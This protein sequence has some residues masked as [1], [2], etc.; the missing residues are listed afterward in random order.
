MDNRFYKPDGARI[1]GQTAELAGRSHLAPPPA[2]APRTAFRR[3]PFP[4][5]PLMLAC[6]AA[7]AGAVAQAQVQVQGTPTYLQAQAPKPP[8]AASA[9]SAASG[10]GRGKAQPI[11][12]RAQELRGRPDLETVA[13]GDVEFRRGDF[14]LRADWLTYEQADDT[15]LARG[16]VRISTPSGVY[17]GPEVRLAIER[18]EGYFLRPDFELI[19]LKAGGRADRVDFLDSSRSV[20]YNARYTSCP[21]DGSGD[22][23]WV[24]ETRRVSLDLESNTGVADGA[25]LR[26]LGV[27]ILALPT[28]SF[29]LTDDRKSGW[30]PP[31]LNLDSK[32]GLEVG[33][34]YYWNIAP[35]RDATFVPRVL[36]RRGV[37]LDSEF[38]YLEPGYSGQLNLDWLP[39]DRVAGRSRYA[40]MA[41]HDGEWPQGLRWHADGVRVSDDGWWKD[42]PDA[43]RG[44]TSRLL[45]LRLGAERDFEI[46]GGRGLAYARVQ[47]WQ[48]LQGSDLSVVSPYERVPQVGARW[49]ADDAGGGLQLALESEVNRFGLPDRAGSPAEPTGSRWHAVGSLSRPWRD[50]GWWVVPKASVNAAAYRTDEAMSD[51]RRSAGRVIPTFSI[52]A[53]LELER[54]TVYFGR[55][56]RQ[57]LEP[58]LLYV[59][60]PFRAQAGLPNFDSTGKDFNFNSIYSEN[61]FSGIDRVSD[62]HQVTAGVTTRVLDAAT[63]AEALRLGI[64]QR[65]LFRTQQ[66]TPDGTPVTQRFSDV[67]LLGSTNVFTGWGLDAAVQYSA[68]I[69]RPVR[70]IVSSRWSPGEFRTVSATYRY[71]RG[72]SEQMELGW[73]WPVWKSP[74]GLDAAPGTG[75]SSS[76]SCGGS[77]YAVGRM[78]YSMKDSRITDSVLG[79]EYDAGCWIARVVSVR[80]STGR[81][82]ATT[83]LR[84]E[85]ELVG[86]SRL[87]SNPLK[88][89]KDNI[90]GYRLLREP[91]SATPDAPPSYE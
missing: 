75:T 26:F 45:P 29:P 85:L 46:A 88:V 90:P 25:V 71:A 49:R 91:R 81:S 80:L 40:L 5:R 50:A 35:N 54:E 65:Y 76:S 36:T 64:V 18:F 52:D 2:L 20:A 30:L 59:T 62:A 28:L 37:A 17:S 82:Q 72:L 48:V 41:Q 12:L 3:P 21:R 22:P 67:Y 83:G 57:T 19:K 11:V 69:A 6:A 78:N 24:M 31:S 43:G 7:A 56:L 13:Q 9:A 73:Q 58:R 16:Q 10:A 33:V 32:S 42:F 47:R 68:D 66:V 8:V 84:F 23:D 27:P 1:R 4:L 14:E 87:G 38:R 60:T 53:G 74:R 70:S 79:V 51:G 61:A 44:I 89:L 55:A 39:H 63:G 86:L 77:L 34:P 15:A